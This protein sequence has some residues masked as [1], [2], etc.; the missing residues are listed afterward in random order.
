M[1]SDRKG[2]IVPR[3]TRFLTGLTNRIKLIYRLLMD[4]RVNMLLKALP[5]SSLV[6]FLFPDLMPGPIDD[7][8]M[9]W[10]STYLFVELCPPEV[11]EE[12]VR[13]INRVITGEFKDADASRNEVIEGEVID[14]EYREEK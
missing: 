3:D 1:S 10:L 11:V 6:Y 8:V 5:I 9:I 4:P 14:A 13:E 2:P 12:H 7:A